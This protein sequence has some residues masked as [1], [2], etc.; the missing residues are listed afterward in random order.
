M[1]TSGG[2]WSATRMPRGRTIATVLLYVGML[3]VSLA[4]NVAQWQ[5]LRRYATALSIVEQVAPRKLGDVVPALRASDAH[6]ASVPIT[7]GRKPTLIYWTRPDDPWSAL[8][9]REFVEI[10]GLLG[11]ALNVVVMVD[12]VPPQ[13]GKEAHRYPFRTVYRPLS[14]S[15]NLAVLRGTPATILVSSDAR[16]LRAW[17]GPYERSVAEIVQDVRVALS[18][19][20]VPITAGA[21]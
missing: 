11:T 13:S 14:R 8:S 5:R 19:G 3:G 6:G 2:L 21:M 12:A 1:D 17:Q 7:D 18:G 20:K 15:A 9:E 4:I 10:G 16:L